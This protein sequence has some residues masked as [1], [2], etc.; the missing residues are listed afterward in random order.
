[1]RDGNHAQSDEL[2]LEGKGF[3]GAIS[4]LLGKAMTSA[5]KVLGRYSPSKQRMRGPTTQGLDRLPE[6]PRSK[7]ERMGPRTNSNVI[8][9]A[10]NFK[11]E[12]L[13]KLEQDYS[14]NTSRKAKASIRQ[15]VNQIWL[16][17]QQGASKADLIPLTSHKVKVIAAVLSTQGGP[18]QSGSQLLDRGKVD[19]CGEGLRVEGQFCQDLCTV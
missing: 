16:G 14:S 4:G 18:V 11:P 17:A 8:G 12:L 2:G 3:F 19:A 1:M 5:A 7:M 9:I 13:V 10:N 15:T 6:L